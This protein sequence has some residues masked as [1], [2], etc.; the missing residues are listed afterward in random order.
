MLSE[1]QPL[2]LP[3]PSLLG[4]TYM[5]RGVEV[6]RRLLDHVLAMLGFSCHVR[7]LPV[8]ESSQPI[9]E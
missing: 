1:A 5:Y 9:T 3:A 6:R 8:P 4:E 2:R 7:K